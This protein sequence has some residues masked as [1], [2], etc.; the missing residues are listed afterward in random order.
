MYATLVQCSPRITINFLPKLA[1]ALLFQ[2]I[3]ILLW[4]QILYQR[5]ASLSKM[6]VAQSL[7]AGV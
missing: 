6:L 4:R 3:K 2:T 5:P 7:L 1:I